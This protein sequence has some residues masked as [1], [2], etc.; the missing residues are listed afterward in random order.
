MG[1][2]ASLH[3]E[4]WA[5]RVWFAIYLLCAALAVYCTAKTAGDLITE[6]RTH[7][8]EARSR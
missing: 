6:E 3:A 5:I 2:G 7:Q 1:L 4:L 8:S